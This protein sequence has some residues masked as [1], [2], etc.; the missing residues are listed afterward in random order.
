MLGVVA[1]VVLEVVDSYEGG[2]LRPCGKGFDASLA[3]W[4]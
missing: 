2:S 4:Q 3:T 1:A